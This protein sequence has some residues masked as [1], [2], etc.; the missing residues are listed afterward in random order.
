MDAGPLPDTTMA[1]KPAGSGAL[2]LSPSYLWDVARLIRAACER[3]RHHRSPSPLACA[4]PLD[5]RDLVVQLTLRAGAISPASWNKEK[6]GLLS[7]CSALCD[8]GQRDAAL[9]FIKRFAS[10]RT[11]AA[12]QL[13]ASNAAGRGEN[14]RKP[15]TGRAL[16][17]LLSMDIAGIEKACEELKL[18]TAPSSLAEALRLVRICAGESGTYDVAEADLESLHQQLAGI[19]PRKTGR[20]RTA[21]D[22]ETLPGSDVDTLVAILCR[23]GEPR[24]LLDGNPA[25]NYDMLAGLLLECTWHTGLRPAEWFQAAVLTGTTEMPVEAEAAL[26]EEIARQAARDFADD[27]ART[28]HDAGL[29]RDID[30]PNEKNPAGEDRKI[31]AAPEANRILRARLLEPALARLLSPAREE[32]IV[33]LLVQNA[34]AAEARLKGLPEKRLL[35]IAGLPLE[36]RK[37]IFFLCCLRGS[38]EQ[39]QRA[40]LFRQVGKRLTRASEIA[41]PSRRRITLYDAR[42]DF[43]DRA[44]AAFSRPE[45]MA[46]MG[47]SGVRSA[48][49]YGR[50]GRKQGSG[51]RGGVLPRPDPGIVMLIRAAIEAAAGAPDL[52]VDA[53]GDM[54]A[55]EHGGG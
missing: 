31:L 3:A 17:M 41:F 30:Q 54:P 14:D 10:E 44:R 48:S 40:N 7:I 12:G 39:A 6:S 33:C 26:P 22:F 16:T 8:T 34:K 15:G 4:A 49:H 42:H 2:S 20:K 53:P 52:A 36:I 29:P 50:K 5:P 24:D 46:L 55:E 27:A 35:D 38:V 28:D 19:S 11:K 25:A 1:A 13:E 32:G 18:M 43:A 37:K 47:H 9:Q 51:G 21:E 23:K 45:V